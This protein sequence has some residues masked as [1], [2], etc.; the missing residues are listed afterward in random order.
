MAYHMPLDAM[1]KLVLIVLCD[2]AN[3]SGFCFVGYQALMFETSIKSKSTIS[4]CLHV[5]SGAGLIEIRAHSEIG[6]GRKVNT[7][8]IIFDESWFEKV[9]CNPAKSPRFVLIDSTR[10]EPEKYTACT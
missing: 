5:L 10:L 8:Q 2:H 4:K 6:T 1:E 3:D 7:Y 9:I